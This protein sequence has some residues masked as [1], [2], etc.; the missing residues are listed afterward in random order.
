MTLHSQCVVVLLALVAAAPLDLDAAKKGASEVSNSVE[1]TGRDIPVLWRDPTDIASRDLFYGAGGK[2]HEPRAPFTFVKEEGGGTS[3]KFILLDAQGVHWVAKL[4]PEARAETAATRLV[5]AAG[6]FTDEDYFLPSLHVRNMPVHLRRGGEFVSPGGTVSHARLE[7]FR[8]TGK[9]LGDWQ[10]R[11][12]PFSGTRE[13]NGLRVMMALINNWDLKDSNNSIYF[14]DNPGNPSIHK[15]IYVV[16]D[17]GSS[18]GTQGATLPHSKAKGNLDSYT[19]SRFVRK[20]SSSYVDFGVPAAPNLIYIFSPHDYFPHLGQR[21]I[22]RGI[23]RTDVRWMGQILA[24]LSP[25]QIR[26]AFR[27]AGYSPQEVDGFT[28]VLRN[29]IAVLEDL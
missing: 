28:E 21:W 15:R 8:S 10:W 24:R 1:V 25:N 2:D 20:V 22:G 29:R 27:A 13:L 11:R 12:S 18:F 16:A 9:S 7:R 19:H 4:G 26:D 23:P 5:W 17:L 6:Y 3:P 14:A